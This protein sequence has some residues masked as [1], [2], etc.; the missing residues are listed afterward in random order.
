MTVKNRFIPKFVN[1]DYVNYMKHGFLYLA[2]HEGLVLAEFIG[3]IAIKYIS[4]E[5]SNNIEKSVY[6]VADFTS[7]IFPNGKL[8]DELQGF[9]LIERNGGIKNIISNTVTTCADSVG[10]EKKEAEDIAHCLGL[11]FESPNLDTQGK[12][13]NF[14]ECHPVNPL[15]ALH[16]IG[17]VIGLARCIQSDI[18]LIEH[19]L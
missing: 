16:I 14:I 11:T 17:N 10:I 12:L 13:M 2:Y 5:F 8:H 4:S 7:T 3:H 9:I 15:E 19:E 6:E 1:N 18:T